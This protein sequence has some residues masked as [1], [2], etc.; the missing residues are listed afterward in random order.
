MNSL[1]K[2]NNPEFGTIRST[3]I[4]GEPWFIGKDVAQVLEYNNPRDAIRNHVDSE[5]KGVAKCDTLGGAQEFTVINESGLYSLILQSKMPKARQ[6]KRW[7]TSEVL[8]SIRKNGGYIAGQETLT[9]DELLAKALTVAMKKIE[10]RDK[11]IAMM[12]PK[13]IF[14]D[15]VATS[16]NSI[17][18]GDLAKI[19]KGNGVEI[20]QKRLFQWLRDNGYLIKRHGADYNSPTQKSMELKLM[21]IKET[22]VAHADGHTTVNKT[23]KITGK[24]QQ[25]FV[26]KFL[27][28]SDEQRTD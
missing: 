16:A 23:P 9:D 25:Y 5:D 19:L 14:A 7:V 20:G 21:E 4:N 17:L 3:T 28:V 24:G 13:E 15:A 11:Q 2:F 22:V 8:P 26:N 1:Q 27:G 10:D 18:I 6:F 12:K